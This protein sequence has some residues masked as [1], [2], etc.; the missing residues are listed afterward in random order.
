MKN[1]AR[2]IGAIALGI[3][4]VALLR[5]GAS[6]RET[7]C[8]GNCA[9]CPKSSAKGA[10]DATPRQQ[11]NVP[12]DDAE[13]PAT[14]KTPVFNPARCKDCEKC[15]EACPK[16]AITRKEVGGKVT[17]EAD[18]KLC[19]GCGKC[20]QSCRKKAITMPPAP[21]TTGA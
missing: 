4:S 7:S 15:A 1:T 9:A 3:A 20:A 16:G 10:G 17:Y 11:Q 12:P 2:L 8:E 13:K 19:D 14:P 6:A 21:K 18:P 5:P